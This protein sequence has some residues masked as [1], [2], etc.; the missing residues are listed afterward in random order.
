MNALLHSVIATGIAALLSSPALDIELMHNNEREQKTKAQL[1]GILQRYDVSKWTFT[2]KIV[3]AAQVAPH[4]HPV[5]T[6]STRHLDSDDEL[7]STYVH[8]QL[9]WWLDANLKRTQKAERALQKIYPRTP[10]GY[11][12]GAEDE[13]SN[14]LHLIDC[15]L[16]MQADRA[17]IGKKGAAEVME[18]WANDHYRWVY[19]TVI[20]DESMIAKIVRKNHL[21]VK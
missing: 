18:F 19:R 17:L 14:Y 3:I 9:H 10:L 5:L 13:E 1:E 4:S 11:P 12:E 15:Y 20:H 16:E 21:E 6:L 8:E 7:L 2:H